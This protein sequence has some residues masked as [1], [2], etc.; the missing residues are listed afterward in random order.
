M[1]ELKVKISRP[2]GA[3]RVIPDYLLEQRADKLLHCAAACQLAEK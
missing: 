3:S 1:I 2:D